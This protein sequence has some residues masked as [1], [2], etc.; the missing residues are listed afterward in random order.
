MARAERRRS[1]LAVVMLDLNDFKH[2]ND[3]LGH[4]AGDRALSEIASVLRQ[5][6]RPY[7]LCARY[8]GDEFVVVLWECDGEQAGYRRDDIEH[9]VTSMY[10]E[11][12]PGEARSLSVSGGVAVF[13]EDGDAREDLI[14]TADRRMYERKAQLKQRTASR[15]AAAARS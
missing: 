5:M 8:G 7:D 3:D 4:Q 6:V 9:A 12:C 15:Q 11:G 1:K 10:F 13:P 2:I 14:A